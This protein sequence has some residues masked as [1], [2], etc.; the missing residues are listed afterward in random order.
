MRSIPL[1]WIILTV[2]VFAGCAATDEATEPPAGATPTG[3]TTGTPSTG[4]TPGGTVPTDTS[5]GTTPTPSGDEAVAPWG[6]YRFDEVVDPR[7]GGSGRVQSYAFTHTRENE[8]EVTQIDVGVEVLGV[9][10]ETVRGETFDFASG[11]SEPTTVSASVEVAKLRHTITVQ[12]DDSGEL[13]PGD[14]AVVTVWMPLD[15]AAPTLALWQFVHIDFE[16]GDER[17]VWETVPQ[18]A[19]Q[20]TMTLPYTE[21]DDPTSWW[22]FEQLVTAYA[23][24]WWAGLFQAEDVTLEEGSHSFGGFQYSAERET[25]AVSG[26]TFDGWRVS[27]SATDVGGSSGGYTVAV[28]PALPLPFEHAFA[29]KTGQTTD[30]IAYELTALELG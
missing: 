27:W 8:G 25:L 16:D 21:G 11:N 18:T 17:G 14:T 4:T 6:A 15:A 24:S 9:S 20:T 5:T 29:S 28:A 12:R 2:A 1:A 22:G 10:T 13:T 3:S 30:R 7:T 23:L 19:G 26:Y